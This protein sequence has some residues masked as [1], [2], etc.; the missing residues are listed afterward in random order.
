MRSVAGGR[1]VVAGASGFIGRALARELAAAGYAVVGLTRRPVADPGDARP[2][3]ISWAAWDGR[4]A[5][6]WAAL[7]DGALAVVNLAGDNLAE[8]RWTRAKKDRIR[9]SRTDAGAAV[10]E[11]V[12]AA[13]TKPRVVVQASAVG[14][15]G[16]SGDEPLDEDS[17]YGTGFLAGVV[18][19]WET[20]TRAVE[21]LGI[22]R[23]VVRSGLVL[24]TGGGVWPRLVLPFRFFGG[25]PLGRGRQGFSW[26]AL[27]DEVRAIR[28]LIERGDLAGTFNLTAPGAVR[29]RDFCREM[30]RAIGRPC[31]LPVPG[32]VLKAL[33]GEKAR[34]TL[35]TGQ[36]VRPARLLAAGFAFRYPDAASAAASLVRRGPRGGSASS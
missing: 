19:D 29:Q 2:G 1:I 20:S 14:A 25:G 30:G 18:R 7:A 12:R 4:T 28:F 10:V 17:P 11:A 9:R 6:G 36:I 13:A 8:G 24:G 3:E 26:I 27:E 34:E 31:W 35:L 21:P 5:S 16:P 32:F 15:Y 33:F 22:R 23:V